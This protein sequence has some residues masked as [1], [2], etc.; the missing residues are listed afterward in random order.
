M[1][2]V[3]RWMRCGMVNFF[4]R[5]L[6]VG[7]GVDGVELTVGWMSI[8]VWFKESVAWRS[9]GRFRIGGCVGGGDAVSVATDK[10]IGSLV[11]SKNLVML[12]VL[13][14]SRLF[15]RATPARTNFSVRKTHFSIVEGWS[16]SISVMGRERTS[17]SW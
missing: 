5:G 15:A 11:G 13:C 17:L 10:C 7:G 6:R 8:W 12:L 3:V 14:L 2:R 4:F 16:E 1:L 9:P